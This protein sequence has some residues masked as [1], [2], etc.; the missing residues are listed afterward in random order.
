MENV[1][2]TPPRAEVA[3][4][5]PGNALQPAS[6]S[7]NDF[8]LQEYGKTLNL[9]ACFLG[10][11]RLTSMHYSG[12]PALKMPYFDVSGQEVAARFAI[13]DPE[14]ETGV[15]FVWKKGSKAVPY[16]LWWLN[17]VSTEKSIVIV[18]S[19]SESHILWK[20]GVPS[21]AVVDET[22]R[23]LVECLLPLANVK[24]ISVVKNGVGSSHALRLLGGSSLKEKVN[25][26]TLTGGHTSLAS[27]HLQS[28]QA[29][30]EQVK[31]SCRS[32]TL[33]EHEEKMRRERAAELWQT[34]KA[35]AG[36]PDILSVFAG[37][38]ERSGI[39]GEDRLAKTIYLAVTSRMLKRPV[40]VAV[41]GPSSC[42]KSA[43]TQG[44][45]KFFPPSAFYELS[46]MTPKAL[47]YSPESF[48]HRMLVISELDGLNG[49]FATYLV[50]SLLSESRI[51]YETV[52]GGQ[53]ELLE[54]NGP[55]GL[56]LT[57]TKIQWHPENETRMLSLSIDDSPEQTKRVLMATA[58]QDRQAVEMAPWH[59]LQEWLAL[60]ER[61]VAI[62]F[63][64]CIPNLIPDNLPPRVRRDFPALLSLIEAHAILHQATRQRDENGQ[65]VA[66]LADYAAVRELVVD[67]MAHALQNAVPSTVRGTVEAVKAVTAN[68]PGG[69]SETALARILGLDKS[70][71]SRRLKVASEAGYLTNLEPKPGVPARWVPG[72]PMPE[73]EKLLPTV[74][75]LEEALRRCTSK[76]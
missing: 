15:R 59:A 16:G 75:Q 12:C 50:R 49:K 56:I 45:L 48:V 30:R 42:G 40:S 32:C 24:K 11:F 46:S 51:K 3:V 21:L 57:T 69:A 70:V 65:I 64:T 53:P 44:T 33:A 26:V 22:V 63:A 9:P 18:G 10:T 34:C 14:S 6:P 60:S 25:L 73:E 41:K 52:V 4:R 39:V 62:P 13:Q 23:G 58:L 76:S 68:S 37:N 71:V 8:M 7:A 17:E 74:P 66:T 54:K 61:R 43:T 72:K 5:A 19:E 38:L 1:E 28:P 29:F 31:A 2:S 47:L 20:Y 35:L 67:A 36:Q 55:T 27:I